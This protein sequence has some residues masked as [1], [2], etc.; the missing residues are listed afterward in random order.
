MQNSSKLREYISQLK[1]AHEALCV[2]VSELTEH[3]DKIFSETDITKAIESILSFSKYQSACINEYKSLIGEEY[4]EFIS[5]LQKK[6]DDFD[7]R[8]TAMAERHEAMKV[9]DRFS[10]IRSV[11]EECSLLLEEATNNLRAIDS[12]QEL[13]NYKLAVKKYDD[14]YDAVAETDSTMKIKKSLELNELF[15]S[16]LL[17][18]LLQ[19]K[20][21][22]ESDER[23]KVASTSEEDAS[24][25]VRESD[26]HAPTPKSNQ[27]EPHAPVAEE[28]V[29]DG[30]VE[31]TAPVKEDKNAQ[32]EEDLKIISLMKDKGILFDEAEK[33]YGKVTVESGNETPVKD[34]KSFRK[35]MEKLAKGNG[36]GV[37]VLLKN[38]NSCCTAENMS[39]FNP[40]NGKTVDFTNILDSLL[41][42][43][44]IIR[45]T[46]AGNEPYY[47]LSS[48]AESALSINGAL[49]LLTDWFNI[50]KKPDLLSSHDTRVSNASCPS[51]A[52]TLLSINRIE[53]ACTYVGEYAQSASTSG[54]C[55]SLLFSFTE[56]LLSKC[57]LAVGAF[58][59]SDFCVREFQK[60]IIDQ[61]NEAEE[62]PNLICASYDMDQCTRLSRYIVS[63]SDKLSSTR[64]IYYCLDSNGF[65]DPNGSPFDVSALKDL[66]YDITAGDATPD[67]D[68][69]PETLDTSNSSLETSAQSA[70]VSAPVETASEP[71]PKPVPES[72]EEPTAETNEE[73]IAHEAQNVPTGS[74]HISYEEARI[75]AIN[76]LALNKPY[77][78]LAYL[79]A[80]ASSDERTASLY[81]FLAYAYNDPAEEIRYNSTVLL[82][83]ISDD[84]Y[85][86][87]DFAKSLIRTA[88]LRN[89]FSNDTE[90]DHDMKPLNE[91]LKPSYGN[92]DIQW[93]ANKLL[94]F[95][96]SKHKGLDIYCDYYNKEHIAQQNQIRQICALAKE[97]YNQ[98][99]L[100]PLSIE[101]KMKR[102]M[103][104]YNLIFNRKGDLAECLRIVSEN[105]TSSLEY[106]KLI[107]SDMTNNASDCVVTKED[108]SI[109][110]N[111]CWTDCCE[112]EVIH[113]STPLVSGLW[114]RIESRV[115]R[116]MKAITDWLQLNSKFD[117]NITPVAGREKS[118][119]VEHINDALNFYRNRIASKEEGFEE[120]ISLRDTLEEFLSKLNGSYSPII[121]RTYF[122]I[123][124]LY[125]RDIMLTEDNSGVLIP[126]LSD[127]CYNIDDV[128]IFSRLT[129]HAK[130]A[131]TAFPTPEDFNQQE[132]CD[133]SS[134]GYITR[135]LELC[136][137]DASAYA[138]KYSYYQKQSVQKQ[139]DISIGQVEKNF[140]EYMELAQCFGKFD[141]TSDNNIKDNILN[142]TADILN[143][144]KDT[145]NYGF[146]IRMTEA[147][148]SFVEKNA[149]NQEPA[150]RIRLEKL[151][152][153]GSDD[154]DELFNE[155]IKT[156]EEFINIQNYTAAEDLINRVSN[157]DLYDSDTRYSP[158]L[159][160]DFHN[161]YASI[162]SICADPST[163]LA[164]N[165][166]VTRYIK[167][168]TI[169][170]KD[171]TGGINLIN[172][173]ITGQS[174]STQ[175]IEKLLESLGIVANVTG[176]TGAA[177]YTRRV[178]EY[179]E[180]KL[181]YADEIRTNY[182]HIFAP[183][184]SRGYKNTF[185]VVCL[186]GVNDS[187]RMLKEIDDISDHDKDTIIFVDYA[188]QEADRGKL[189]RELKKRRRNQIY[190]VI[191][192]VFITYLAA[193]YQKT[194]IT[195]QLMNLAMPFSY[196]QPYV[197]DSISMTPEMFIGRTR[198]LNDIKNESGV[199]MLYGGRQLGKSA[200]LKKAKLEIDHNGSERAVYVDIK[201]NSVEEAAKTISNELIQAEIF[202][203][204]EIYT[205]WTDLS[206]AIRRAIKR[207]EIGY[208]L[209]LL[210]EGDAFIED[211][212]NVKYKPID[213]LKSIMDDQEISFKFVIAGLH[214]LVRY[215]HESATNDNSVIPHLKAMT[216]K[217]FS[218]AEAR[219]LLQYPLSSLG[220]F[221]RDDEKNQGLVSTILATSNYFPGLIHF[222]CSQLVDSLCRDDC[223]CYTSGG[224]PPYYVSEKQIQ[225]LLANEDFTA[226]IRDKFQITLSLD[227]DNY[228]DII[229]LSLAFLCHDKGIGTGYTPEDILDTIKQ[230]GIKKINRA[231]RISMLM[232]E[233]VDLNILRETDNGR[234]V[235]S[236]QNFMQLMGSYEEIFY[237]LCKYAD[238]D[239]K[240]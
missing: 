39:L 64:V 211:C 69:E 184:G 14:F 195:K 55:F 31:T 92:P 82:G 132:F 240:R 138:E 208:L 177:S 33:R 130:T 51:C 32:T 75:T 50:K 176:T 95:K 190:L 85:E 148:K 239:E 188:Y 167:N 20:L 13:D 201:H 18:G 161:Q 73:H 114:S 115:S 173:W 26:D 2:S 236:R 49:S 128:D 46:L 164:R 97:Y 66:V 171:E 157:G 21:Y 229:A 179:Y 223:P 221:F 94:T 109:Y 40:L 80:A 77:C 198:E 105:E 151:R 124:F 6:A 231:D 218:Y 155:N 44:Y 117:S 19:G 187:S 58:L 22:I 120:Y 99:V 103:D 76:M 9:I 219:E 232:D 238:A 152:E 189:A 38:N 111:K 70:E 193:H 60:S 25:A 78:A 150:I 12:E 123:G 233:L 206:N 47:H 118:D 24:T 215:D 59:E 199:H 139:Q 56:R 137:R 144:V 98:Y 112:N 170:R 67:A 83:F 125:G 52:A 121:A 214:N 119:L 101:K 210:D 45:Y 4:P 194:S 224:L 81:K 207:K 235:F 162:Y 61:I 212:K 204:N 205:D 53:N 237:N 165:T 93:L 172:S 100:T 30:N 90:H 84:L 159:L 63:L 15:N 16:V 166:A 28:T 183:F 27:E 129:H 62:L 7:V 225:K 96:S 127:Y 89:F 160:N 106:V 141:I 174:F 72:T 147:I 178:T 149:K 71:I 216:I 169:A 234:Y 108:I 74:R 34:L 143:K 145:R 35:D 3:N 192:R 104:T 222:Y 197:Q 185:R 181:K 182:Q 122:Y 230:F 8:A 116:S 134:L 163:N 186:Y 41:S 200:L 11:S 17:L 156:I 153:K 65:F 68:P 202:S 175:K 135:Y 196:Y 228:Y 209:L 191:D 29:P 23:E 180:C 220:I 88:T 87:D 133:I 48:K 203:D 110:I 158:D 140:V 146:F 226:K 136:G 42:R 107:V 57:L 10:S 142:Q 113:K 79:R 168:T 213:K 43:G 131:R 126:D 91:T 227:K 36:F 86:K 37:L 1:E 54:C 217:P 102:F 154:Q 5:E